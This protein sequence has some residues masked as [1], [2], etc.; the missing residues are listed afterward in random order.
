M[1][2]P[3]TR[4]KYATIDDEDVR[5]IESFRW[6]ARLSSNGNFYATTYLGGGRKNATRCDIQRLLMNP[7]DEQLV[8]HINGDTLDNRRSNLRLCS[9]KEN[10]RNRVSRRGVSVFKGVCRLREKWRAYIVVDGKHIALGS[11]PTEIEAAMVY[12]QA[13]KYYYGAF[14]KPNEVSHGG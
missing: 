14:A 8:D 6:C 4:G 3:L 1:E 13:A 11:Y 5:V 10:S 12:N 2:V 9:K 7:G